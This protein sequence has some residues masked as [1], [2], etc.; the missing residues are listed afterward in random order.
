MENK[1]IYE[2]HNR[3]K[4]RLIDY[5]KAQYIGESKLLLKACTEEIKTIFNTIF[6]PSN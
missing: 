1:G 2:T 5:I 3:L 6:R 4:R